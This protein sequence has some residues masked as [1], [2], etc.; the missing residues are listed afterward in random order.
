MKKTIY[1]LYSLSVLFLLSA[2]GEGDVGPQGPQGPQ[3]PEGPEGPGSFIFEYED[4]DFTAE[5]DYIV[6]LPYP[7][8]FEGLDSDIALVYMYNGV[9]EG[10]DVWTPLPNTLITDNGI[11]QY[12]YNFTLGDVK[13]FLDGDFDLDLLEPNETDA[14]IIR[15]VVVPGEFWSTTGRQDL[16]YQTVIEALG[17]EDLPSPG[18]SK[19][20]K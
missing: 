1:L 3:G 7:S 15:V 4:V 6:I 12:K 16:S 11:L 19:G 14:W 20:R 8:D 17:L 10:L 13:V 18:A 9:E 5:N 2:C